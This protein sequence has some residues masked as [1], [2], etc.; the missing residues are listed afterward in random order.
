MHQKVR[1]KRIKRERENEK[2]ELGKMNVY[3][4]KFWVKVI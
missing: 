1:D 2:H 3:N 4:F